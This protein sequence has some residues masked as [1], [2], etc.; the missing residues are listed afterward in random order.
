MAHI[1]DENHAIEGYACLQVAAN[2]MLPMLTHFGRHPSITV[3]R[4]VYQKTVASHSQ[5]IIIYMLCTP[6][7]FADKSKTTS[8]GQG[9]D[10]TRFTRIGTPGKGNFHSSGLRQIH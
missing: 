6:G 5:L 9:V 1:H 3:S 2:Q 4:K 7:C 8:M 10:G